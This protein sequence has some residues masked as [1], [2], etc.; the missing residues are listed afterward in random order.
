M[1]KARTSEN[2]ALSVLSCD[3]QNSTRRISICS[4]CG[5]AIS[6]TLRKISATTVCLCKDSL[7]AMIIEFHPG[8][9]GTR[10]KQ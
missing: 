2:A 7:A 6:C 9:G 4:Q 8:N 3:M 1:L 5:R 10:T